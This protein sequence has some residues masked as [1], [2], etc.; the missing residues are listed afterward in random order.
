MVGGLFD[1]NGRVVSENILFSEGCCLD[2]IFP[3]VSF[4]N[5][6]T[7]IVTWSGDGELTPS[8]GV[9]GQLASTSGRK[10]GGNLQFSDHAFQSVDH[11]M[12]V[13]L[14]QLPGENF[15]I[16]WIDDHLGADRVFARFFFSDGTPKDDSFLISEDAELISVWRLGI[17]QRPDGGFTAVW[18]AKKE[19]GW[20]IQQ[21][22]FWEDST[23]AATSTRVSSDF[24]AGLELAE[25]DIAVDKDGTCI[26]VWTQRDKADSSH[27]IYGQRFSPEGTAIGNNFRISQRG[28]VMDQGYPTVALNN[29]K[30]YTIWSERPDSLATRSS[31]WCNILDFDNPTVAVYE[32]TRS[33]PSDFRLLQNYPNPFNPSTTIRYEIVRRSHVRLTI[34]NVMGEEIISLIDDEKVPGRY[35]VSWD[36]KDNQRID[37][38]SGIYFC[39]LSVDGGSLSRKILLIR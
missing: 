27:K 39:K 3:D 16:V 14:R 12:A 8:E 25:V 28:R 20:E 38:P 15:V 36:G 24:E 17:G 29:K 5:D 34:Y 1:V 10:I 9:Y 23:F 6:T 30:I 2:R 33:V 18:S 31:T 11:G 21:R 37:M 35:R 7:F 4:L 32:P 19:S 13:V 22:S 26:I